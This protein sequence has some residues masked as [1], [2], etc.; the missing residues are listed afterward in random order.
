MNRD[1]VAVER[2]KAT[3]IQSALKEAKKDT[4]IAQNAL[5]KAKTLLDKVSTYANEK[6]YK[7]LLAKFFSKEKVVQKLTEKLTASKAKIQALKDVKGKKVVRGGKSKMRGGNNQ[8]RILVI[9]SSGNIAPTLIEKIKDKYKQIITPENTFYP[10]KNSKDM[11]ISNYRL[12]ITKSSN[13]DLMDR[14]GITNL[15]AFIK[16]YQPTITIFVAAV[17]EPKDFAAANEETNK[18]QPLFNLN[19]TAPVR[20]YKALQSLTHPSKYVFISSIYVFNGTNHHFDDEHKRIG[21]AEDIDGSKDYVN[22]SDCLEA[23][24]EETDYLTDS[25]KLIW[26]NDL[27]AKGK[28]LVELRLK[29]LYNSSK[30]VPVSIIRMDGVLNEDSEN[31]SDN[32]F[33]NTMWMYFEA[34]HKTSDKKALLKSI[35]TY[36]NEVR[37]PVTSKEVSTVIL[38]SIDIMT[39][40]NVYH[41]A[42]FYKDVGITKAELINEFDKGFNIGSDGTV[43]L[44]LRSHDSKNR[45]MKDSSIQKYTA[46]DLKLSTTYNKILDKKFRLDT[47]FD[48]DFD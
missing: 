35:S 5:K 15:E 24:D 13:F 41:V 27:Y 2:A 47:P 14:E 1:K 37:Y 30:K 7:A 32:T 33:L 18:R 6:V 8:E 10:T 48:S 17:R 19:Y 43:L 23:I 39:T 38:K 22:I 29:A 21:R 4:T 25:T 34:K 42:G 31:F 9:G 20:V 3:T 40:V 45:F 11:D 12:A 16:N 28:R 26:N 36:P 44:N 46:F